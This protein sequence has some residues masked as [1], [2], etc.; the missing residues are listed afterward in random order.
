MPKSVKLPQRASLSRTPVT[1]GVFA[2]CDPRVDA[3]SR[4]RARNIVNRVA[5]VV[6]D[7]VTMPDSRPARVVWSP[8]LVDGEP[9]ADLV[10]QQ[11]RKAGVDAL[12]CAPDTWAFP[13]LG[14]ISVLQ[15]FPKDTP[16]NLDV[17]Q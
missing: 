7:N 17:R 14:L 9:Q 11:F 8:I 16:I 6:A 15:Q 5:D 1:F 3:P 13:Q 10:A 2:T 4:R 12:I